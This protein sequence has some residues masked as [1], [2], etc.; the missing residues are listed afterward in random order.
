MSGWVALHSEDL[1]AA[2]WLSA[3]LVGLLFLEGCALW[4]EPGSER[5]AHPASNKTNK[6]A[7]SKHPN[8]ILFSCATMVAPSLLVTVCVSY[9]NQRTAHLGTILPSRADTRS[10]VPW[11]CSDPVCVRANLSHCLTC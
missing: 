11:T 10:S 1:P 6:E 4:D 7:T 2:A 5:S 3:V 8:Q 9:G